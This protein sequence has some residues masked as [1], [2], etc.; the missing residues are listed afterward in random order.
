MESNI[1]K[2]RAVTQI[3]VLVNDI[4]AAARAWADFLGVEIPP[5]TTTDG[6]EK[7]QARFRGKA[8]TA[9]ARLAFF[10]VG[11]W[12]QLE[13]IQPDREQSTWREALDQKGEGVHHIAFEVKG[14]KEKLS[15]LEGAGMQ[16]LQSGE[17]A[18]GRYAYV[19]GS[20]D[21]KVIIELLEND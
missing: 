20:R 14:M 15:A 11:P 9:R 5:I 8:T 4:E 2:T 3:G 13:L 16:L 6:Y 17:Y 1:L 12:L 10:D 19:D 18:G 21:L 7:S